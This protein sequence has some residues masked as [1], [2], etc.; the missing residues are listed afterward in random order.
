MSFALVA[1]KTGSA[2]LAALSI[3]SNLFLATLFTRHVVLPSALQTLDW[4]RSAFSF[5]ENREFTAKI[6]R[7]CD[8]IV[9]IA[10][11]TPIKS[12]ARSC[13]ERWR[14]L[15]NWTR[16]NLLQL[17]SV[18][19]TIEHQ[20]DFCA[21]VLQYLRQSFRN[22]R[23]VLGTF[24]I[25]WFY[26]CIKVRVLPITSAEAPIANTLQAF[27]WTVSIL[28]S[29]NYLP[30]SIQANTRSHN[31]L[32]Q[33]PTSGRYPAREPAPKADSPS[34]PQTFPRSPSSPK[35]QSFPRTRTGPRRPPPPIYTGRR[36][37]SQPN[38][39]RPS[40][41]RQGSS[42]VKR[43]T[44]LISPKQRRKAQS[45]QLRPSQ[46][47][48]P[49]PPPLRPK[50]GVKFV[51][52]DPEVRVFERVTPLPSPDL[53]AGEFD[54]ESTS[55]PMDFKT[56][57]TAFKPTAGERASR[58]PDTPFPFPSR[59]AAPNTDEESTASPMDFESAFTSQPAARDCG[60]E[61]SIA[62][63]MDFESTFTSQPAAPKPDDQSSKR[64]GTPFPSEPD[65]QHGNDEI[66]VKDG[67]PS[68]VHDP[69]Q[70]MDIDS[71][72]SPEPATQ[73]RGDQPGNPSEHGQTATNSDTSHS[74][75]GSAEPMQPETPSPSMPAQGVQ[76]PQ[77]NFR[78]PTNNLDPQSI[79]DYRELHQNQN[80]TTSILPAP[81]SK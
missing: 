24:A 3:L 54:E 5:P 66:P 79:L 38:Q 30:Q 26:H 65:T 75:H 20:L 11:V 23:T 27:V 18:R 55:S 48:L 7:R 9:E 70:P 32:T 68:G 2:A 10:L 28:A 19:L 59:S 56:A 78:K 8:Q 76:Q 16:H 12:Y 69:A 57:F 53:P 4:T 51:P 46:T 42:F 36:N 73:T 45:S 61:E 1:T 58:R 62:S 50:K 40:P 15:S 31:D 39:P 60:G 52:D 25:R 41:I 67:A 74:T 80:P 64:P 6:E 77:R 14:D 71:P 72:L 22:N 13:K 37:S 35:S 29:P 49:T 47:T 33:D 17:T 44:G 34:K 81:S 43:R 21:G 63:P